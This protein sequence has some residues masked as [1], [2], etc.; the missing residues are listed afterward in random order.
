[1]DPRQFF[2]PGETTHSGRAGL[3]EFCSNDVERIEDADSTRRKI[4]LTLISELVEQEVNDERQ[5]CLK[6]IH[7]VTI[8]SE[9]RA[10]VTTRV[11]TRLGGGRHKKLK[12]QYNGGRK[13]ARLQP[14]WMQ[15]A[16]KNANVKRFVMFKESKWFVVC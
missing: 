9:K 3:I 15:I 16:L 10:T 13:W 5:R 14:R 7:G 1:M 2:G 4:D 11:L 8:E 12:V 6:R